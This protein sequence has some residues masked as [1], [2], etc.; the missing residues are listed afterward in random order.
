[1]FPIFNTGM[2]W[3]DLIT[4]NIKYHTKLRDNSAKKRLLK[5]AEIRQMYDIR[6]EDEEQEYMEL[7]DDDYMTLCQKCKEPFSDDNDSDLFIHIEKLVKASSHPVGPG[8]FRRDYRL[9]K[10]TPFILLAQNGR[11]KAVKFFLADKMFRGTTDIN[12]KGSVISKATNKHVHGATALWVASTGGHLELVR[13][14]LRYGAKVD[15]PTGSNST[16]LRGASFHGH[17]KVMSELLSHEA[18]VNTPNSVGQSPLLIAVLRD[19]QKAVKFL[20][21]RKADKDQRTVNGYTALHLAAAKGRVDMLKLLIDEEGMVPDFSEPDSSKEDHVPSPIF[22]AAST[23][24]E[25]V[26]MYFARHEKC[27]ESIIAD[28]LFLLGSTIFECSERSASEEV[29][30]RWLAAWSMLD[31]SMSRTRK[32]HVWEVLP[33]FKE[34]Q[35]KQE[36]LLPPSG[37]SLYVWYSFQSLIIR[38]R[39]MGQTDPGLIFFLVHRGYKFCKP[40]AG[41]PVPRF[42]LAESFFAYALKLTTILNG[43]GKQHGRDFID[44]LKH[45]LEK[46]L[47]TIQAGLGRMVTDWNKYPDAHTSTPPNFDYFVRFSIDQLSFLKEEMPGADLTPML[48]STVLILYH[49]MRFITRVQQCDVVCHDPPPDQIVLHELG[50]KLVHLHLYTPLSTTLLHL[51]VGPLNDTIKR[52]HL[53]GDYNPHNIV[54]AL[55]EWG[56]SEA[57]DVVDVSGKRPIHIACELAASLWEE[58]PSG[59]MG[60]IQPL[61]NFN[62]EVLSVTHRGQSIE[63]HRDDFPPFQ[64]CFKDSLTSLTVS[65]CQKI[66]EE[67]IPYRLYNLPSHLLRRIS[68]YDPVCAV[69]EQNNFK[70]QMFERLLRDNPT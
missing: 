27:P 14:L 28:A 67:N 25:E 54:T 26:V 52:Y 65:I 33:Q 36:I 62:C 50:R 64:E 39:I 41:C 51:A 49:W 9:C 45:D 59:A 6:P 63:K 38:E 70:K 16:P 46:D 13:M 2:C 7:S 60:L 21:N 3:Y 57:I 24:M 19:Q 69:T 20:L 8:T 58:N 56:A 43:K 32:S 42:Q 55:L 15:L 31:P 35:S 5:M 68:Y 11:L 40:I 30:R 22:L 29:Q 53:P 17:I 34:F 23:K 48:A 37:M 18:N 10:P 66:V 44:T 1:M 61:L 47:C 12:Q 4:N